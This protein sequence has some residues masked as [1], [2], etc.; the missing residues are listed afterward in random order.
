M[1]TIFIIVLEVDFFS[2]EWDEKLINNEDKE[3]N[4]VVLDT[5][6][7]IAGYDPFSS[8]RRN[9]TVPKVK[10]EIKRNSILL[11]RFEMAIENG[12]IQ[13]KNPL[14]KHKTK[15][16]N[17]ANKMGDLHLLS[18]T[19]LDVLAIALELQT[20]GFKPKIVTDDYSIQNVASQMKIEFI[21]LTTGGIHK[22]FKWIR[23]C[24]GCYKEFLSNY[25]V[26][27]CSICGTKLKRKPKRKT[28]HEKTSE[29]KN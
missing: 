8:K 1:K 3:I 12:K 19:D 9:I 5:S 6:A 17:I 16:K 7:F 23:Y 25:K 29:K 24:P 4:T 14:E 22:I 26:S 18:E 11:L 2:K 10:D 20:D 13:L 27:S 15:V 21:S 28:I